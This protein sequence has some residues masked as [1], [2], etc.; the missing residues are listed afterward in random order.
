MVVELID[1]WE[2]YFGN[3]EAECRY[4]RQL[5]HGLSDIVMVLQRPD[6]KRRLCTKSAG[7]TSNC[8]SGERLANAAR[9]G[10]S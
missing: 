2:K 4:E 6:V 1:A 3:S 9:Q 10:Q 5:A 8:D 7:S